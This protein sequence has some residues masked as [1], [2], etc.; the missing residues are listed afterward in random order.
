MITFEYVCSRSLLPEET[1][2]LRE[3]LFN[4]KSYKV[5]AEEKGIPDYIINT[6]VRSSIDRISNKRECGVPYTEFFTEGYSETLGKIAEIKEKLKVTAEKC[7]TGLVKD[8]LDKVSLSEL[9]LSTRTYNQL[10]R[11]G[12]RC[13]GDFVGK[14]LNDIVGIRHLGVFSRK[15]ILDKLKT[16]GFNYS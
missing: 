10:G 1:E 8:D 11:A 4:C 15:E 6:R 5:L 16:F 12:Y 7:Q 13:L 14:S 9:D 3:C 2:L